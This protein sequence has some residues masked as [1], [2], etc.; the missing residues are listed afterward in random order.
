MD[1]KEK[2]V[3]KVTREVTRQNNVRAIYNI[4]KNLNVSFEVAIDILGFTKNE[5]IILNG[6]IFKPIKVIGELPNGYRVFE[7]EHTSFMKTTF[8]QMH[9]LHLIE[10]RKRA[11]LPRRRKSVLLWLPVLLLPEFLRL[12][13]TEV[14]PFIM[15]E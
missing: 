3:R 13:L 14:V 15:V 4:M 9:E 5:K 8:K 10:L 2:T 12:P 11:K 6:L 7:V 1:I